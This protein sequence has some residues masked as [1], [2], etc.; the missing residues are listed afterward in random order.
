MVLAAY[1]T[2]NAERQ[3]RQVDFGDPFFL[4]SYELG[5]SEWRQQGHLEVWV[6]RG[7]V[8]S[9]IVVAGVVGIVI[10]LI[11]LGLVAAVYQML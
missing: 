8:A 7:V 11:G 1:L 6:R 5:G 10:M 4:T 9:A 3:L 2:R